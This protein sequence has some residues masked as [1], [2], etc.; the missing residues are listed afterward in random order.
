MLA[1]LPMSRIYKTQNVFA[2]YDK[3]GVFSCIRGGE[4]IR[5][6]GHQLWANNSCAGKTPRPPLLFGPFLQSEKK[7]K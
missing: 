5:S 4:I 1:E 6:C 3:G 7:K 2:L